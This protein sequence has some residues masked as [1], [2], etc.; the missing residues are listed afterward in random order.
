MRYAGTTALITGASS[1]IGAEFARRFARRGADLVLVARRA[2]ALDALAAEIR[3]DTGRTVHVV[4]FDLTGDRSGHR[5]AEQLHGLGVEVDTVLNCAGVAHTKHFAASSEDEI[6]VQLRVNLEAVVDISRAFL[7]RL[8]E[9]GRGALV[10]VASLTGHLS[11]PG[12]AV[13]A[14]SKAFVVRFT[15]ALAHET[16]GSGLTVLVLSPGPTRTEFYET[17]GTAATGVRFQ[18]SAQVADTAF[19]ALDSR[20]PPV[21]V[22]SGSVNRWARRV[23]AVLPKRT[24]LRLLE[25]E[26]VRG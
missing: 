15:E 21:G 10:N 11:V 3:A 19:D 9:S 12:M 1:G 8:T 6:R 24:A 26:P 14:A 18:T 4:P 2:A 13:Y 5:L 23:V 20:R 25:A 16:R 22:I 17:S 7:P